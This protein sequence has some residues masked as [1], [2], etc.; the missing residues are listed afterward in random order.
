MTNTWPKSGTERSLLRLLLFRAQ[1][2]ICAHCAMP[3]NK[4]AR[5]PKNTFD[6]VY[7]F[8]RKKRHEG[9]LLLVHR[10]CNEEK[11]DNDPTGCQII[12]LQAVNRYLQLDVT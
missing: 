5:S 9:N 11:A 1:S 10:R 6:H 7:P 4:R 3:L 8:S 12:W 2:G